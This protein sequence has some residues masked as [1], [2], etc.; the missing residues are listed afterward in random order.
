MPRP[1][2]KRRWLEA[3]YDA[4]MLR[5]DIASTK[6]RYAVVPW[7]VVKVC[8]WFANRKRLVVEDA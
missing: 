6:A 2:Y 7:W 8:S 1:H 3:K 4:H 5:R